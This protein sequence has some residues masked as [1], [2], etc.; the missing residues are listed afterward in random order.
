[1]L[2]IE[3]AETPVLA[4]PARTTRDRF[5]SERP[6]SLDQ[7]EL[8]QLRELIDTVWVG[9]CMPPPQAQKIVDRASRIGSDFSAR[10]AVRALRLEQALFM[11]HERIIRLE[12]KLA[13]MNKLAVAADKRISLPNGSTRAPP[14]FKSH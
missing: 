3:D 5:R 8:H 13:Q 9:N 12:W 1:M 2:T 14:E 7:A 6:A 11:A 4:S 10:L